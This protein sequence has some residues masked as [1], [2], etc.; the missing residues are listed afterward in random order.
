MPHYGKTQITVCGDNE[1][2]GGRQ[3]PPSPPSCTN[4]WPKRTPCG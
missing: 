3:P 1:D 4:C 2:L